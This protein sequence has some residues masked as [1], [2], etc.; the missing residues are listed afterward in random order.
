MI[1]IDL[2]NISIKKAKKNL[3]NIPLTFISSIDNPE[4][5][6]KQLY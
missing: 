1:G 4:F 6:F 3:S 2:N 5:I